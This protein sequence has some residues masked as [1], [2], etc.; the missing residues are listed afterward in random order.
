MDDTDDTELEEDMDDYTVA[1]VLKVLVLLLAGQSILE[2]NFPQRMKKT[3][4]ILKPLP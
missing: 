1:V 3:L 4:K 2:A